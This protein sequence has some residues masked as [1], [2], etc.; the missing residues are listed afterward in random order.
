M[1]YLSLRVSENV[2]DNLWR[3][4]QGTSYG[5]YNLQSWGVLWLNKIFYQQHNHLAYPLARFNGRRRQQDK[6]PDGHG[7]A[8][9]APLRSTDFI[10]LSLSLSCTHHRHTIINVLASLIITQMHYLSFQSKLLLHRLHSSVSLNHTSI[11]T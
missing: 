11:S 6:C 8:N 9:C 5:L 1:L 3:T 10:S 2:S 4:L 7:Q